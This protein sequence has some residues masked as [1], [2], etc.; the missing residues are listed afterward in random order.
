MLID[1]SWA[2]SKH[3]SPDNF[4]SSRALLCPLYDLLWHISLLSH[5]TWALASQRCQPLC[6]AGYLQHTWRT[7]LLR[8]LLLLIL[9]IHLNFC[10]WD[11]PKFCWIFWRLDI[12]HFCKLFIASEKILVQ[13]TFC[14][15]KNF[16]SDAL[17]SEL[18]GPAI[19]SLFI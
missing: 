4:F 10:C 5:Q 14:W 9:Q 8:S 19:F 6:M 2:R 1:W 11:E 12:R 16:Q 3:T 15:D 17:P 13:T 7:Y 18:A